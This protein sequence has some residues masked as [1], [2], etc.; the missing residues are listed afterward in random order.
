MEPRVVHW[1]AQ[2]VLYS[3]PSMMTRPSGKTA[4]AKNR[5]VCPFGIE[6]ICVQ[7]TQGLRVVLQLL[8]QV[9]PYRQR[10]LRSYLLRVSSARRKDRRAYDQAEGAYLGHRLVPIVIALEGSA[11]VCRTVIGS[12][13]GRGTRYWPHIRV[14]LISRSW[15]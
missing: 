1:A 4:E 7:L 10:W 14:P 5:G 12:P 13:R 3:P 6:A 2:L 8:P 9:V 11:H 15:R